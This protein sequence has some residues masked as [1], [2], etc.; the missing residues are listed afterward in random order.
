MIVFVTMPFSLWAGAEQGDKS[1]PFFVVAPV[2]LIDTGLEMP[3]VLNDGPLGAWVDDNRIVINA[4]LQGDGTQNKRFVSAMLYDV[5]TGEKREI[6]HGKELRY[7]NTE[8][9]CATFAYFSDEN[10]G[11]KWN[12]QFRWVYAKLDAVGNIIETQYEISEL[13]KN[14]GLPSQAYCDQFHKNIDPAVKVYQPLNFE[15]GYIDGGNYWDGRKFAPVIFYRP[16]GVRKKLSLDKQEGI[17]PEYLPFLNKYQLNIPSCSYPGRKCPTDI[18]LM[19]LEG[20]LE[21]ISL[22]TKIIAYTS[23]LGVG[24][25]VKEGVLLKSVDPVKGGIYLFRNNK[26]YQLWSSR[27]RNWLK[28]RPAEFFGGLVLSPDGC[29]VAFFRADDYHANVLRRVYIFNHCEIGR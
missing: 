11:M 1:D 13:D 20:E 5:R 9:R 14:R 17:F 10:G 7:W 15:H 6:M 19:S 21:T 12:G 8:K 2:K 18:V 4:H 27:I 29:K 3:A 25:V 24:Y 22:P 28:L 26:L 23:F 16:D